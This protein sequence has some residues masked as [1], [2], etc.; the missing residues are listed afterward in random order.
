MGTPTEY[1]RANFQ[2][3]ELPYFDYDEKA[4]ASGVRLHDELVIGAGARVD[5]GSHLTRCIVWDGESVPAGTTATDGVFA[6]GRFIP[7]GE[8]A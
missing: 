5:E 7:C 2:P 3:P 8:P 4:R 1:L 6:D